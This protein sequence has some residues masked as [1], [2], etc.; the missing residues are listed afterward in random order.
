MSLYAA[1][2][3]VSEEA[4]IEEIRQ[5]LARYGADRVRVTRGEQASIGF[6]AYSREVRLEL[7]LPTREECRRAPSGYRR[8]PAE[9]E[10][11]Y[12]QAHRQCWRALALVVKAKLEAVA[13]G[14]GAFDQEFLSSIVLAD[15]RT[16]GEVMVPQLGSVLALPARSV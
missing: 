8:T 5:T 11:A 16:I 6:R 15:D 13:V 10:R 4:S 9:W 14:I 1:Q 7:T 12:E 3:S 2:T